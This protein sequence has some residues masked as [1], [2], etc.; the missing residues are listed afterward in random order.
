MNVRLSI[1]A[2]L[3]GVFSVTLLAQRAD[4]SGLKF[5]IDPGHGGYGPN[6]RNVIVDGTTNFWESESNWYKAQYLK[7]M[8]EA[9]GAWVVLTRNNNNYPD[10]QPSLSARYTVANTNGVDWFHS[11]HSNAFNSVTNYTLVLYKEV[12]STRLPAF[13]E[14][15]TMSG[16]ISKKINE[17]DRTT[18]NYVYGD[19]SFY[20]GPPNGYNLGV[21]NGAAMPCELSEGSFH[22]VP[23]ETRRL[24]N[25]QYKKME[26]YAIYNSFLQYFNVPV[27]NYGIVAGILTKHHRVAA[28]W[29]PSACDARK[30][31]LYGR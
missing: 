24:M 23:A 31:S 14:A 15:V 26:A 16:I 25:M 12:I 18:G 17:R 10:G 21:L 6:D 5:C 13:P 11:I 1:V 2:F 7:A 30:Y 3:M 9:R 28:Q 20:G 4:L 22:D 29:H 27:D 19:Y 8:L